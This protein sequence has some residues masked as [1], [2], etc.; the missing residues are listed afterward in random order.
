MTNADSAVSHEI[1]IMI[2]SAWYTLYYQCQI[3]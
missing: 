2:Q 3:F 1:N